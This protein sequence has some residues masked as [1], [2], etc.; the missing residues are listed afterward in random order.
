MFFSRF[1]VCSGKYVQSHMQLKQ[2]SFESLKSYP[3]LLERHAYKIT[4]GIEMEPSAALLRL[5]W[6]N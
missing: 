3:S 5:N 1:A 2:R 6:C 4:R